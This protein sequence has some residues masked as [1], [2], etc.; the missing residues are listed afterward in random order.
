MSTFDRIR[1]VSHHNSIYNNFGVNNSIFRKGYTQEQIDALIQRIGDQATMYESCGLQFKVNAE[2]YKHDMYSFLANTFH[3]YDSHGILPFS[4]GL[5][6]Q[7]AQII[8]Y[9][10][11]L[12]QLKYEHQQ[13]LHE[14]QK[15]RNKK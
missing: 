11:I 4:G 1:L 5:A 8:E 13:R 7:P 14:E 3:S 9:F 12:S 10:E 6:D 15:K 2:E